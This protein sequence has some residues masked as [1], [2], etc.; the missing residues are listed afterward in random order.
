[1]TQFRP[2]SSE[3]KPTAGTNRKDVFLEEKL[4]GPTTAICLPCEDTRQRNQDGHPVTLTAWPGRSEMLTLSQDPEPP[5][6]NH[7]VMAP[8]TGQRA[9]GY[10]QPKALLTTTR[11]GE[12]SPG[13]MAGASPTHLHTP[14]SSWEDRAESLTYPDS[15]LPPLCVTSMP[16]PP[17][18]P[19]QDTEH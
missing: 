16:E 11:T 17:T 8:A 19:I 4:L 6:S 7:L 9:H 2:M 12:E 5:S 1:M 3:G 13:D 14:G 10:L 18:H 15:I